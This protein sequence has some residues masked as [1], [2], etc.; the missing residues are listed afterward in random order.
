[1]IWVFGMII[2]FGLI[3]C[4]KKLIYKQNIK[5][6]QMTYNYKLDN[7]VSI[8]NGDDTRLIIIDKDGN[9]KYSIIVDLSHWFVKNNCIV[10][11]M[12]NKN[13][14]MLSFD[15]RETAQLAL[16]KLETI[17]KM[18]LDQTG[19]LVS[20]RPTFNTLNIQ[21]MCQSTSG[22]TPLFVSGG[23]PALQNNVGVLQKPRSRV[24]VTVNA[25]TLVYCGKPSLDPDSRYGCYFT[26]VADNGNPT[27]ARVN[28]GDVQ[29]GDILF[30]IANIAG[31]DI[32]TTD[33][34][35]Y[36]YFI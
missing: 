31:F 1:M 7:F 34:I 22:L 4:I 36:E 23:T 6:N 18:L 13:D 14:I 33:R 29:L 12:T 19:Q 3:K 25:G 5:I 21:M 15:S 9:F 8:P 28:D 30:W 2:K 17:R 26:S 27:L 24:K 32:D 16:D 35:D 20:N 10:I 11:K